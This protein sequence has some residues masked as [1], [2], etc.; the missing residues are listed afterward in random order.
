MANSDMVAPVADA[1]MA[2]YPDWRPTEEARA[3]M[4][5]ALEAAPEMTD[6]EAVVLS[7]LLNTSERWKAKLRRR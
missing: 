1:M 7:R 5:A 4:R 2:R 3:S 6:S